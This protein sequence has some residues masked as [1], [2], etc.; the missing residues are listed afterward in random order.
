MKKK[1]TLS[2]EVFL[3]ENG[4]GISFKGFEYILYILNNY[5]SIRTCNITDIYNEIANEYNTTYSRVERDI[6]Y[7]INL[8]GKSKD[9]TAKKVIANLIYDFNK[10]RGE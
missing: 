8:K 6:R 3:V 9:N 2:G 1:K 7:L 4:Y 10:K 5:K